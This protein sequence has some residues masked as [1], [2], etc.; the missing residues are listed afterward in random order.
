[1]F[2]L[3]QYSLKDYIS[4]QDEGIELVMDFLTAWDMSKVNEQSNQALVIAI[5]GPTGMNLVYIQSL[6]DTIIVVTC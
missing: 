1:M 5:T 3:V 2:C 4:G 6:F